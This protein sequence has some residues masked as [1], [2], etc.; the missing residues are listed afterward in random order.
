MEPRR[1]GSASRRAQFHIDYGLALAAT[2]RADA[3]ALAQFVNAER[4]APQRVRL[5]PD[6]R[7]TVGAMLRRAQAGA[8][9]AH[10]RQLAA[11]VGVV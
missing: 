8:G 3:A 7:D 6:V 10:L 2:R 5:S 4:I 1:I 9:G 11:R